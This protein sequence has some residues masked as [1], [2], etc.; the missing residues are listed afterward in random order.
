MTN[1]HLW[2]TDLG[3]GWRSSH[4]VFRARKSQRKPQKYYKNSLSRIT[5]SKGIVL[6]THA[7]AQGGHPDYKTQVKALINI[8][9]QLMDSVVYIFIYCYFIYQVRIVVTL[10]L[11]FNSHLANLSMRSIVSPQLKFWA[12]ESEAQYPV[13]KAKHLHV[14]NHQRKWCSVD[15]RW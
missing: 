11:G 13:V 14:F 1:F 7:V 4:H 9:L 6:C 10:R 8:T 3:W 15:W 5:Q 12:N 2:N